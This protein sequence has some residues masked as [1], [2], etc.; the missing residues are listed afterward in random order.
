MENNWLIIDN[1]NEDEDFL[2][3]VGS[4]PCIEKVV[5]DYFGGKMFKYIGIKTDKNKYV[6]KYD[7]F[8]KNKKAVDSN[9]LKYYIKKDLW[10]IQ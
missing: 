10:K 8:N 3:I 7:I 4:V 9:G 5:V 2:K 1:V 6:V